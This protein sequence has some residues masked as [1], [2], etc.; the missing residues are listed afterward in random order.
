MAGE[1]HTHARK[2][3]LT[4]V[5]KDR[6]SRHTHCSA[7]VSVPRGGRC[8]VSRPR[9]R[10]VDLQRQSDFRVYVCAPKKHLTIYAP[11]S[12][13]FTSVFECKRINV[14]VHLGSVTHKLQNRILFPCRRY[15]K[16][17]SC[18][19]NTDHCPVKLE[20]AVDGPRPECE[21]DDI[22]FDD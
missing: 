1:T 3:S 9:L 10:C 7:W 18:S 11:C 19:Q 22:Y 17:C 8:V 16:G 5:C 12:L 13:R 6:S 2:L 15:G 21:K 4:I 14:W 20:L